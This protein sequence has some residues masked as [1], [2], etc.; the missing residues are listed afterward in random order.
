MVALGTGLAVLVCLGLLVHGYRLMR[1]PGIEMAGYAI[2]GQGGS[3]PRESLVMKLLTFLDRVVGGRVLG[4]VGPERR[5][6][7]RLDLAR[8]GNPGD[9]TVDGFIRRQASWAVLGAIAAFFLLVRGIPYGLVLPVGAWF[10]P[11]LFLTM[12]AKS[13]AEAIEKDLPDFLDVLTVTI[14]AGLGFRSALRRVS[15][16]VGGAVGEE[17][18]ATLRQIDIGASRRAAFDDM[19]QRNTAPSLHNFITAFLQAEELG[20]PI[21]GFLETYSKE[22]RRLSGQRARTAAAKA[23]PKISMILT[24]VFM[25][26]LTLFM[27]GSIVLMAFMEQ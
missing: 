1:S 2:D 19:R 5:R 22:L 17:M 14:S 11:K 26:S 3:K 10:L 18:L 16:L 27:I 4:Q 21:T 24:L 23:N 9:M 8:A 13:R 20:T 25:P 15:T 6:K 7:I 12:G